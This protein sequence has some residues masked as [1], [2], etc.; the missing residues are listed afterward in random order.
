M[1]YKALE[2]IEIEKIFICKSSYYYFDQIKST[3]YASFTD[4][5][6]DYKPSYDMGT[7]THF[8]RYNK[9][10]INTLIN[11]ETPM[12]KAHTLLKC[13]IESKKSNLYIVGVGKSNFISQK[14][15]A[16]WQSLGLHANHLNCENIWHG[17]FGVFKSDDIIIYI[18][19]S[20]N[21]TEIFNISLHLK[22][23]FKVIQILLTC[24]P[25][26]NKISQHVNYTF[27]VSNRIT[28]NG[29]VKMA[30]TISSYVL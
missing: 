25:I 13:L 16:T 21:T 27:N 20:G 5:M 9:N 8:E 10:Y 7:R 22:E 18:S 23:N 12:F 29:L 3:K 30:P 26:K 24:N 28:E 14:C 6:L 15:A 11:S 19:N 4:M 1:G 17:G 2:N